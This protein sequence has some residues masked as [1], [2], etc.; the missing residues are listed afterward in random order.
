MSASMKRADRLLQIVQILRRRDCPTTAM[1]LATELEVAPRTIYRDIATLQAG[2]VPIDGEAGVG[3]VLRPG[4]DLPPLMFDPQEIEAVTLGARMV[5]ERGDP[6]LSRAAA[7]VLAKIR[8]VLPTSVGSEL[9]KASLLVPHPLED[10]VDLGPHLPELRTAIRG[11][12]KLRIAY[13]DGDRQGTE[14][15]IWPLGLYL[16]SH[17]TLVCSWCELRSGYRA[18][19]SDRISVCET[20]DQQFDAQ[21]GRLLREY[22]EASALQ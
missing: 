22:F 19:R 16:Y 13:M 18:F 6:D 15:T 21:N 7:D 17:V 14:R 8:A 5:I 2:R 12:R 20:L 4:Y 1:M 10:A 3:Y 11:N 9:W